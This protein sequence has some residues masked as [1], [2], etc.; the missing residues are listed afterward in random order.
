M[1]TPDDRGLL[2]LAGGVLQPG[3]EG[4]SA[5]DWIRRRLADGLGSVLL[6]GRN[7]APAPG[8]REQA[9]ALVAQL[10]AENPDVLVAVDEEGGDVTRLEWETGSSS[11]GNLALGVVD[12]VDLTRAVARSIGRELAALGID[13]D[14][15]PDADV[16]SNPRN[17]VIGVRSFG[18]DQAVVARHAAAW[19]RG[20]QEGGTAACAKHFPGHGAT[21]VDSHLGL[22]T[23]DAD[24]AELSRVALPPFRA[25]VAAGARALMTAHILLPALDPEHPATV[26]PRVLHDVLRRRLGFD[27]LVVTDAVE[28]RAVADRYG[29]AGAAVRAL[30]AGADLVCVGDRGSAAEYDALR[31]AVVRAV[32]TGELAEERLAEAA[33]RVA[34]FARWARALRAGSQAA[35]GGPAGRAPGLAAARRALISVRPPGAEPPTRGVPYVAELRPGTTVAVGAVTAWGLAGPL[36]ALLPGTEVRQ[37]GHAEAEADPAG[38]VERICAAARGRP[39]VLVVRNAHRHGWM[40]ATVVA[41]TARRPDAVVVE[42][43]IAQSPPRGGLHVVPHGAA[44][45]C[46]EAAAEVV[47]AHL[48]G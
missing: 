43:G 39:L 2:S 48:T 41:V 1:G 25:A 3:F 13:V 21:V 45:V 38:V 33:G 16:N 34:A 44:R 35:E 10:R 22:P 23:V 47:A 18:A 42:F 20:L 11:P 32:R 15:A 7:F 28:M 36:G 26:S 8:G 46:A 24:L 14:Y 19:V 37:V 31:S 6:F 40:D 27:G 5:P 29:C 9:S 12:D 4:W 17:P 30:A